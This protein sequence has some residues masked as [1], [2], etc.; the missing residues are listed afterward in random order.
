MSILSLT[1]TSYLDHLDRIAHRDYSVTDK[2]ILSLQWAK[3]IGIYKQSI[4]VEN[5]SYHVYDVHSHFYDRCAWSTVKKPWVD[6][7]KVP[8]C[9]MMVVPLSSYD[10][11]D[12]V[13][14][15]SATLKLFDH[16]FIVI[17]MI[18]CYGQAP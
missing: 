17:D 9:V 5:L 10:E 13:G 14:E 6:M 7:K 18:E 12:Y 15:V 16:C 8:E 4:D 1:R 11:T 3:T 2:D